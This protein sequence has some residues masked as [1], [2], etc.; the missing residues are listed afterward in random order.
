MTCKWEIVVPRGKGIQ[1]K[2]GDFDMRAPLDDC[3]RG[4]VEIFTGTGKTKSSLGEI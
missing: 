2:F 4:E 1:L 3:D